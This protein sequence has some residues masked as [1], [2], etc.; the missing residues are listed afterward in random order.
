DRRAERLERLIAQ[1]DDLLDRSA[2]SEPARSSR[3]RTS[4][5]PVDDLAQRVFAL[6]DEGRSAV[7]IAQALRQPVGNIELMLAL[8][9]DR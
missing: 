6:A 8:R 2:E 4:S 5:P 9:G 7:Q 1:A 3:A